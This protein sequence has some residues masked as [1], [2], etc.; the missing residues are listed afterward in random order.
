MLVYSCRTL[1]KHRT[2]CGGA[3][4]DIWPEQIHGRGPLFFGIYEVC[5]NYSHFSR[6]AMGKGFQCHVSNQY[7]LRVWRWG[8]QDK[9]FLIPYFRV[10][11]NSDGSCFYGHRS[12]SFSELLY[13]QRST[14]VRTY[15]IR[16]ILTHLSYFRNFAIFLQPHILRTVYSTEVWRVA[17]VS[18]RNTQRYF[19]GV[20]LLL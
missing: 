17:V 15:M 9:F 10:A 3:A 5:V 6:R 16:V 12:L 19:L 4:A 18:S 8:T 7:L 13:Y 1:Y 20:L 11:G 2:F 14:S